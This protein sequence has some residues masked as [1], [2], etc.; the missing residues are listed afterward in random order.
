MIMMQAIAAYYRTGTTGSVY[1]LASVCGFGYGIWR[2]CLKQYGDA[3]AKV[4]A[5][6]ITGVL[7]LRSD[8]EAE[9]LIDLTPY[10]VRSYV[11]LYVEYEAAG[12]AVRRIKLF[13]YV[14]F[15]AGGAGPFETLMGLDEGRWPNAVRLPYY[16]TKK[17]SAAASTG[18]ADLDIG[19]LPSVQE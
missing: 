2:E 16:V 12:S 9:A 6:Q 4:Y 7:V 17:E 10:G 1:R 5:A 8:Q 14:V 11:E 19:Q 13:R 3:Q 18:L 15:G